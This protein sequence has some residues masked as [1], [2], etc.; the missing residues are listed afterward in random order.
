VLA[1]RLASDLR[2]GGY[3]SLNARMRSSYCVVSRE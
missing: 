2:A 3:F 1:W